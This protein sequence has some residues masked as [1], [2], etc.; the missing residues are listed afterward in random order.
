MHL[1]GETFI[2]KAGITSSTFKSVPDVPV[3]TF[4]LTLPQGPFSALAA[5][6]DLCAT[7]LVMPTTFTAQNG[8]AL[9]QVTKIAVTDCNPALRVVGHSVKGSHASI[10]VTVPSAG[11]LAVAGAEIEPSAKRVAKAGAVTI[12]VRLTSHGLRV[13]A[14]HP[15]QRVNAKVNLRFTPKHGSPLAAHVRLLMG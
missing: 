13:L 15:H 14:K 11:T 2:S 8:A 10:G 7:K 1:Q 12:G 9:K 5:N 4:E 3:S 6:R